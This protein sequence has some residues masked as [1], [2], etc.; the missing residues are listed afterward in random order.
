MMSRN[1][2][3]WTTYIAGGAM[4]VAFILPYV[5]QHGGKDNEG[6]DWQVTTGINPVD[7]L[8]RENARRSFSY[9]IDALE[10]A[11]HGAEEF[12]VEVELRAKRGTPIAVWLDNITISPNEMTGT[13][14]VTPPAG[15]RGDLAEGDV[16]S[17]TRF[18]V[19]DWKYTENGRWRG[20]FSVRASLNLYSE[21]DRLGWKDVLHKEPIP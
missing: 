21:E 2:L 14:T 4:A 12:Q 13:L 20:H 6:S 8:A 9:F 18:Q 10:V 19:H 16:T 3:K 11:G 1:T 17:F 7:N 15:L 5:T